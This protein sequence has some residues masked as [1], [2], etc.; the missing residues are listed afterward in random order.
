VGNF[1][2]NRLHSSSHDCSSVSSLG[3]SVKDLRDIIQILLQ[4]GFGF[5][6]I[7]HER[8]PLG[9]VD[10]SLHPEPVF[11]RF[12]SGCIGS[13][14]LHVVRRAPGYPPSVGLLPRFVQDGFG[15]QISRAALELNRLGSAKLLST[16][17][18]K[19][20]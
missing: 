19:V 5:F 2:F 4:I 8:T 18:I 1:P 16:R 9:C 10:K 7:H 14:R 6:L 12:D 13:M 17:S 15:H 11:I 3:V 20:T